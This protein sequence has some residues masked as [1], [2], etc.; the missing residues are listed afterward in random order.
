MNTQSTD[1]HG[2]KAP[3]A[4]PRTPVVFVVDDGVSVCES[5]QLLLD[6]VGLKSESFASAEDFLAHP[7]SM[8]PTCLLLDVNLPDLN[9]LDLQKQVVADRVEMPIIF[10]TGFADIPMT[11]QAMKAG[12][13][14]F[15][16]KPLNDEVLLVAIHQ[17]LERSRALLDDEN[18]LRSI[19]K[20]YACLSR[21]ESEVLALVC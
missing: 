21:R 13:V 8:V 17:G 15:L 18:D 3:A 9:G 20:R 6:C 7:R 10:M 19:R 12:A 11:V 4:M 2:S 14:E 16:T 1:I 5:L